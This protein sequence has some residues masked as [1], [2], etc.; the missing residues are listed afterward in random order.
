M[1]R[2]KC[3]SRG[4]HMP[5]TGIPDC[6]VRPASGKAVLAYFRGEAGSQRTARG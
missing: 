6:R 1:F 5:I 4:E 3:F 2:Q